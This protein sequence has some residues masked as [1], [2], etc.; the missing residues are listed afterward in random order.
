MFFPFA[1]C[2]PVVAAPFQQ[3]ATITSGLFVAGGSAAEF[4][5]FLLELRAQQ[6]REYGIE[7]GTPNRKISL[8]VIPLLPRRVWIWVGHE[9]SPFFL[10]NFLLAHCALRLQK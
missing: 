4:N 2:P 9:E 6:L 10:M 7:L 1:A 5:Q 3:L 8:R